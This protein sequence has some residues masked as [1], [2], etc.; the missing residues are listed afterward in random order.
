MKLL[1][2]YRL[3]ET[4]WKDNSCKGADCKK[5]LKEDSRL[6][7]YRVVLADYESDDFDINVE[8]GNQDP[9]D[10]DVVDQEWLLRPDQ[11]K[12]DL[13]VYLSEDCGY[14]SIYVHDERPATPSD[15]KRLS[16]D[17]FPTTGRGD[18]WPDYG[19]IDEAMSEEPKEPLTEA[20]SVAEIK[21]EI[22][23]L[24]TELRDAERAERAATATSTTTAV[25]TA[26]VSKAESTS[27]W[28]WDIYLTPEKKG[29]WTGI[30]ND[31]V[32]ETKD[33]ALDAAWTLLNELD[34]E[35]E[36]EYD[37]DDYYVEAFEIPISSVSKE[38]LSFSN[39][40]HLI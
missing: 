22:R 13:V 1:E 9:D 39:L 16:Q 19:T 40:N 10:Y 15:L 24:M 4:M 23:A 18:D 28:T 2:E 6:A 29:T 20:R 34:D 3:Y 30:Q 14:T 38:V 25:P 35:G 33:K 31:L 17:V 12:G 11:S 21:A 26:P 7:D 37:P 5:D 8:W 36:L 32:F 27:V